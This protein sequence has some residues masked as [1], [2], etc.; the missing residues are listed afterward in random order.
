[1]KKK[2][3]RILCVIML[4]CISLVFVGCMG[5]PP[6]NYEDEDYNPVEDNEGGISIDLYGTKVLYRPESYDFNAGSGGT[7][8]QEN[9]YYGQYAYQIMN[10]IF[11]IY[12]I[13]NTSNTYFSTFVP[14]FATGGDKVDN[15]PYLYDSI[16]YKID[17]IAHVTSRNNNGTNTTEPV[18]YYIV[19]ADFDSAWNWS[20]S[21][22]QSG[23]SLNSFIQHSYTPGLY[24]QNP[25]GQPY[26]N[27]N[28]VYN[29]FIGT[30]NTPTFDSTTYY[31]TNSNVYYDYYVS[32]SDA[33][34]PQYD[35]DAYSEFTKALE[36]VIYS[37]ALDLEP[38]A[39][40]VT[41]TDTAPYYQVTVA[42]Y[43]ADSQNNMTSVDVALEDI[44]ATF[45]ELGAYVGLV[46]RQITKIKNWILEN[47]IGSSAQSNGDRLR[48]YDSVT[49]IIDENGDVSY[50]F[51][52]ATNSTELGRDYENVLDR[53]I[54]G[55]CENVSI[56]GGEE[57]GTTIDERFLA[58][59]LTE[60]VGNTFM[61][62]DDS[63][64]PV[65][66]EDMPAGYIPPLEYQSVTIMPKTTN[67]IQSIYIALKYD[68]DED[69]TEENVYNAD[70]YIDI[71]VDLNYYNHAN[72]AYKTLTS[73]IV[74]VFD[75]P[76]DINYLIT[77]DGQGTEDGNAPSGH[78]SGVSFED[79]GSMLPN[80]EYGQYLP[81]GAFNTAVAG[82]VLNTDVA[83]SN[84]DGSIIRS[85]SPIILTGSTEAKNWYSIVE[86][87]ELIDGKSYLSGRL[88]YTLFDTDPNGCD[89]LEI[90]YKVLK[91]PGDADT[92]YK[93]Y[94]GIAL[95]LNA[96]TPP[97]PDPYWYNK[98]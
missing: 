55:V 92:N 27:G 38:H 68:A 33:E 59:E 93:F 82:G 98:K 19:G 13:P 47:V 1:M 41:Q 83:G 44:K 94:T 17:T 70:K 2:I 37:Y 48:T 26:F 57:G 4:C 50:N 14:Q 73:D 56:G 87:E 62:S 39:I 90:T 67:W 46:D 52:N 58:S 10:N 78:A 9:D 5:N 3:F 30:N 43:Q 53:L 20:F 72:R 51:G 96:D 91:Q 75:G 54:T 22:D 34:E 35:Y 18:D 36:Y 97:T 6:E 69:G 7:E 16:R 24:Y 32:S 66:S 71:Q 79:I 63:N 85:Q 23:D 61:I 40:N 28:H 45:N 49:E 65:Y 11:D 74:R 95:I 12:A 15:L 76:Y 21:Y 81:V 64:F 60:Y 84:Y 88:N 31:N 86:N 89:Y 29:Y 77:T 8:E 80:N 42:G 25:F